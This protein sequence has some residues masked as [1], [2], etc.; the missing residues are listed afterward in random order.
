MYTIVS[1]TCNAANPL[2]WNI[3]VSGGK[4]NEVIILFFNKI[5]IPLVAA[6]EQGEAQTNNMLL[7]II[8]VVRE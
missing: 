7:Y 4:E 5:F 1:V 2:K 8:G 6:S 3:S